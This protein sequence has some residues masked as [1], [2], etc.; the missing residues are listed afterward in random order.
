MSRT[1]PLFAVLAAALAMRGPKG[2]RA[3]F[4]TTGN[5]WPG[6]KTAMAHRSGLH[7]ANCKRVKGRRR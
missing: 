4:A 3:S 2:Y 5:P 6:Y 1:I 7:G